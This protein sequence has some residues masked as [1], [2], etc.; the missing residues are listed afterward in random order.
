MASEYQVERRTRIH[1]PA[2]VVRSRIVDLRRWES[3]SPWEGLDPAQERT[4]GGPD[5]GEG[6]WYAW[7]G[8][9]KAGEGRMEVT[10]A[11]D[12]RVDVAL[13]FVK[14][15]RSEAIN[16]FQFVE[17]DDATEVVWSMRGENTTLMRVMGVFMSMEKM[18]G[19]QFDQGLASLKAEAEAD[20]GG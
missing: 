3:W 7:R 16:T 1:A 9:R 19:G 14:P 11:D 5:A 18:L 2:S 4:Y 10:H 6:A 13:R 15:F 17:D 20:A 12:E 8:N